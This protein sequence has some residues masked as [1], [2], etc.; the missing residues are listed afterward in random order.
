MQ[1]RVAA[2]VQ[3]GVEQP[4]QR[5]GHLRVGVQQV[6]GREVAQEP[7]H[8]L[9][10]LAQQEVVEAALGR[11]QPFERLDGQQRHA[12]WA[13]RDDV[14]RAGHS[15]QQ[16]AF[17]EPAAGGQ[18]AQ[19]HRAAVVGRDRPLE[20]PLDGAVPVQRH[21]AAPAQRAALR[22]GDLA[23]IFQ[24]ALLRGGVQQ[25]K[26]GRFVEEVGGRRHGL[27][28]QHVK[29]LPRAGRHGCSYTLSPNVIAMTEYAGAPKNNACNR[30]FH[31]PMP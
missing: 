22:H 24:H 17:T 13:Q 15:A 5:A 28:D 27:L 3:E 26:P 4:H 16:R 31:Q 19:S 14:R 12:A 20:Q 1:V 8:A 7:V 11:V 21:L 6:V 18:A 2:G 29:R 23:Q 9:V 30:I 25:R 10:D